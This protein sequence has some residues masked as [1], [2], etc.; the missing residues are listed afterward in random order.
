M[1]GIGTSG[2]FVCRRADAASAFCSFSAVIGEWT[3]KVYVL[4]FCLNADGRRR[5][6]ND[7]SG[8][9]HKKRRSQM[10]YETFRNEVLQ[11]L[12][13]REIGNV[14]LSLTKRL[15]SNGQMKYG[16]VFNNL[17]TN[18]SPVVY[19]E[20]YYE[21]Y[22]IT[23]DLDT[24]IDMLAGLYRTLPVIQLDKKEFFNFS[25][26]KSRIIMKLVNTD[27]N[28]IL[29]ETVP[30]IPFQDL[31]IVYYYLISNSDGIILDMPVNDKLLMKWGVDTLTL[32][33]QAVTNYNRLL[34]VKFG[35]LNQFLLENGSLEKEYYAAI[36]DNNGSEE[37]YFLS[38]EFLTG[39]AVLMTCKNLMDEI[40]DFFKEDF[41]ILP[42]SV[43]EVLLFP[44]SKAPPKE[45][46][47][48]MIQ[49]INRDYL[50]PEDYLSDHAY[51]YSRSGQDSNAYYIQ[52]L[53][54][55]S[56]KSIS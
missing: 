31:S 23:R 39:G 4:F 56:P 8:G 37:L 32:H 18:T 55:H 27:K 26:A 30:H 20:E 38:N 12:Q 7:P 3:L 19:L 33:Q 15:K 14:S 13:C 45:K 11:G 28:R 1:P 51:Y 50:E 43:N 52:S 9:H 24:V 46:L 42:S 17:T 40:A 25:T 48:K 35:N 41:Y 2:F 54:Q 5:K 44:E 49:E 53:F 29:L 10:T 47:D 22:Q 34:P 6:N 16:V 21:F 36:S